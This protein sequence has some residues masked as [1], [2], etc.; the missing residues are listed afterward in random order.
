LTPEPRVRGPSRND[1]DSAKAFQQAQDEFKA[2]SLQEKAAYKVWFKS[3][4][5]NKCA[6]FDEVARERGAWDDLCVEPQVRALA[7]RGFCKPCKKLYDATRGHHYQAMR[8][9]RTAKRRHNYGRKIF[10][11]DKMCVN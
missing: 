7:G 3:V 6:I 11:I 1:F 8:E 2:A 9:M 10:E 4:G 5:R